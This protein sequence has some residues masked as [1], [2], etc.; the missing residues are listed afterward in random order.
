MVVAPLIQESKQTIL[1]ILT[2]QTP[3]I[4]AKSEAFKRIFVPSYLD[5]LKLELDGL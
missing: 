5:F 3:P 4:R 1:M 2:A